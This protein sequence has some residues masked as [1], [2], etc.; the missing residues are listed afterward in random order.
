MKKIIAMI[1]IASVSLYAGIKTVKEDTAILKL[2]N[3]KY[4][5]KDGLCVEEMPKMCDNNIS[6][7]KCYQY[8]KGDKLG[9][10]ALKIYELLLK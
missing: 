8:K 4:I 5:K 1:M 2:E 9:G 6:V 7:K 10:E 3:G